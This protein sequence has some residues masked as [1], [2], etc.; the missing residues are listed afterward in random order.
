[1]EDY[2]KKELQ[3]K[4]VDS[5]T[6]EII[7]ISIQKDYT[8]TINTNDFYF[9]FLNTVDFQRNLITSEIRM[10]SYLFKCIKTT[11]NNIV[12][13]HMP[14]KIEIANELHISVDRVNKMIQHLSKIS[15]ILRTE[16]RGYYMINP[17]YMWKGS[18]K[19]RDKIVM[20]INIEV[21]KSDNIVSEEYIEYK[22]RD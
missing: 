13:L 14:M 9:V 1:M 11:S 18:L 21:D 6:G 7:D 15:V 2:L 4:V 20:S 3:G 12:D 5:D 19:N 8:V 17:H 16:H 10:L 22:K